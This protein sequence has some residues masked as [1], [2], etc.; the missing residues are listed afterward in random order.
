MTDAETKRIV[1]MVYG[2][3]NEAKV[4]R[5]MQ[6]GQANAKREFLKKYP[7]ADVS[8]FRFEVRLTNDGDIDKYETYFK[9]TER[10][11]FDI[12]SDTFLNNAK[13][14]KYLK[15][16]KD[17]GFGIWYANGVVPKFQNTR[18]PN[19]P[20]RQ[21]WGKHPYI[22]SA[23]QKPVDL[24]YTLNKFKIYITDTEYFVPNFP[25]VSEDWQKGKTINEVTGLDIKKRS[26]DY[27]NDPYFTM[28][29]ATYV[30]SFLCGVSIQHLTESENTPKIITSMARYHLYYQIRRFM[31][32]PS[33]PRRYS[34]YFEKPVK[35]YLPIKHIDVNSVGRDRD[36]N[37]EVYKGTVNYSTTDYKS[38]ITHSTTGL[39]KIGQKLFQQSGESYV[40]SVL[41]SQ[42]KTRW[43]IVGSGAKSMHVGLSKD[44]FHTLVEEMVSQSDVTITLSNMRTAIAPKR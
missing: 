40:Y 13:W 3:E 19:N 41:G 14:M 15:S 4:L 34:S 35:K 10:D 6:K 9:L 26:F 17:R 20:T 36:R 37:Y 39:T 8:K 30:A 38:I 12:T 18:F 23:F 21:G 16:K 25:A 22:D 33:L 11:S 1:D 28:L 2:K 31:K 24:G 5:N 32:D 43:A 7:D 27:K 42:A 44:V 29:C